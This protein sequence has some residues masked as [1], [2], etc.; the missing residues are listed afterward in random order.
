MGQRCRGAA[1]RCSSTTSGVVPLCWDHIRAVAARSARAGTG[2]RVRNLGPIAPTRQWN[3]DCVCRTARATA[4]VVRRDYRRLSRGRYQTIHS[5]DLTEQHCSAPPSSGG[6]VVLLGARARPREK[7][8]SRCGHGGK[9]NSSRQTQL[10][11]PTKAPRRAVAA[12]PTPSISRT[13]ATRLQFWQAT[14][15]LRRPS[16]RTRGRSRAPLLGMSRR[17]HHLACGRFGCGR[18]YPRRPVSCAASQLR[19]H[20]SLSLTSVLSALDFD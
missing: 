13:R 9:N 15:A 2:Q 6:Y 17:C 3:V 19:S 20:P 4:E 7:E 16:T 18:W 5:R 12:L 1:R 14:P 8:V 11:T 10:S